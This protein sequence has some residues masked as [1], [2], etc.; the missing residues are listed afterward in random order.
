MIDRPGQAILEEATILRLATVSP[1]GRPNVA[2]FWYAWDGDRIVIDTLE[3]ATVR[4]LR[5]EPRVFVLVD[6][7][8]AF[9]DLRGV[10]IDGRATAYGPDDAPTEVLAGI[11]AIR[12]RHRHEIETPEFERYAA[13]ETRPLVYVEVEPERFQTYDLGA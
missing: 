13:A 11:E 3:N 9:S 12:A 4:N 7:G 8:E 2:A 10:R 5:R 1:E 6:L